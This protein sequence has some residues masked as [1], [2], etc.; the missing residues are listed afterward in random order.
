M[1]RVGP[2]PNQ[3]T[4]LPVPLYSTQAVCY[5]RQKY[6]YSAGRHSVKMY[7]MKRNVSISFL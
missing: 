1:A 3:K 4:S 7:T 5:Q 2:Q 6:S